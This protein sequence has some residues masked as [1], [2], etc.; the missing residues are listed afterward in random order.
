MIERSDA[1]GKLSGDT[2]FGKTS[3]QRRRTLLASGAAIGVVWLAAGVPSQADTL[4]TFNGVVQTCTGDQSDGVI[5]TGPVE[6]LEVNSLDQG[7]FP[8]SGVNGIDFQSGGAISI[9][10]DTGEHWI[11]TQNA[12]GI[13]ANTT[14]GPLSIDH[15][16]N[17]LAFGGTGVHAVSLGGID[18]AV[19]GN[20]WAGQAGIYARNSDAGSTLSV[21]HYGDIFSFAGAGIDV[22]SSSTPIAIYNAGR[23]WS[24]G[25]AIS[26]V[27]TSPFGI[28]IEQYGAIRS[29]DGRGIFA[30][31]AVGNV[32]VTGIGDVYAYGNGIEIL[33]S[34]AEATVNYSG[35]IFSET[36]RGIM[37]D[38][39]DGSVGVSGGGAILSHGDGIFA[40]ATGADGWSSV[41]WMGAI[42][43]DTGRGV[44]SYAARGPVS[45]TTDGAIDSQGD[46]IF[47]YNDGEQS[48]TVDHS[49]DI[50]AGGRGI[51]A[52]SPRGEVSVTVTDANISS[53]GTAI[54]AYNQSDDEGVS[55]DLTGNILGSTRGIHAESARGTVLVN[56][57]GEIV[58]TE[59]GIFAQNSGVTSVTVDQTGR[60]E[61]G[62]RGI[63]AQSAE[64][65]INIDTAGVID[66][67][68]EGI[69]AL[70]YGQGTI[71]INSASQIDSG[72][73]GI[74]AETTSGS[75]T[76]DSNGSIAAVGDGIFAKNDS[77]KAISVTSDGN[78]DAGGKGIYAYSSR[79]SVTVYS[80]GSIVSGDTGIH[81][82][83]DS[84]LA[85]VG[86][87][88]TNMGDIGADQ[89]GIYARSTRGPVTIA[90]S[91]D[92]DSG[93]HGIFAE[94]DSIDSSAGVSVTSV[95]VIDSGSLGIYAKSTRGAVG[96]SSNGAISSVNHGIFAQNDSN[97]SAQGVTILSAGDITAG[98]KGI[99]GY[100]PRGAVS[101]TNDGVV[102]ATGDGIFAQ[103]DASTTDAGISIVSMGDIGA[104]G[105]GIYGFSTRGAVHIE[106]EGAITATKSGIFAQ[107]DSNT[108]DTGIS[109][110]S[111][112]DIGAG[113]VGVYAYSTRGTISIETQGDIQSADSGIVAINDGDPNDIDG[114]K[115]S[116]THSGDVDSTTGAG[117]VGKSTV[118]EVEVA[119]I[120]GD[121]TAAKDGISVESYNNLSVMIGER[122]SVTGAS[123]YAGVF[124]FQGLENSLVNRGTISNAGGIGE[125]AILAA[126]NDIDV[127]NYG[128]IS[129][130][131]VLGP[132]SNS[133]NNL[134]GALFNMG[135]TV[136]LTSG[137]TLSNEGVLSPGGEGQVAVTNLTGSLTN[138]AGGTLLFDVDMGGSQADLVNVSDQASLD[139]GLALNFV[140]ADA[141]P[142]AYTIITTGGGVTNQSLALL[143]PLVVGNIAYTNGGNDVELSVDGFDFSPTGVFG[144][145]TAIGDYIGASF[146]AGSAGL[147]P[148]VLALLNLP[149]VDDVNDALNQLSPD[150]YLGDQQAAV[151]DALAFS[152]SMLSCRVAGGANAFGAEGE[153]GW[154]RVSYRHYENSGG[155]S[156]AGLSSRSTDF[157]GGAQIALGDGNW[158]LGGALGVRVSDRTGD[159]GSSSEGTSFEGG[160][161][162]K[163]APGPYLL[164]GALSV[165]RGSY[166]TSRSV[167]FPGFSDVLMGETDVS[168]VNGRLRA[169]YTMQ[170]GDFY[171][172]PQADFDTT[173]VHTGAFTETGG[174]ASVSTSATSNTMFT[175]TPSIEIGGQ[176]ALGDNYLLRPY[177]RGGVSLYANNDFA[178]S[179]VFVADTA[180]VTP[181]TI[182]TGSDEV[183]W[184][185]AAGIDML[186]AD[187]GTVQI[188]YGGSFGETTT[189][190]SAG[191]KLSVDF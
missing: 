5:A 117:I 42:T 30:D 64:G 73:R 76:I 112:G 40:Q 1:R 105:F 143:N 52:F 56:V 59:H 147:D 166:D 175:L 129:G 57:D 109:I 156:Q 79:G 50:D 151:T 177:L 55:V 81:A 157:A 95:G 67:A 27:S 94:N 136:N 173:Y 77:N 32:T 115:I 110:S 96:V 116:I 72:K 144:N 49:G 164:A 71:A 43:S 190:H 33:A 53:P 44:Y 36:G 138:L 92:I 91:G 148:I 19:D 80:G 21:M 159:N 84:L 99:Y 122:A 9:I 69:F 113:G 155:G 29:N 161:V 100:S 170:A 48:V 139:G 6:Q 34:S 106:N 120:D 188:F 131:V 165:S 150:I 2:T 146:Q 168:T 104:G 180:G 103:N 37:V 154:G 189:V 107:N 63:H 13:F 74:Y 28:N 134:G 70:N 160:A 97:S 128:T 184:N 87:L 171:F 183:L 185:V 114:S 142:N 102:D 137:N 191:A 65:A 38:A 66:A 20:I 12:D 15:T 141:T 145:G 127:E 24:S 132:W 101:I 3:L 31:A 133:F 8:A 140:S 39:P 68:A 11:V 119:L 4:C 61:T 22:D 46:G 82:Q 14:G 108:A 90:N 16:G 163:Y 41:Y 111:V 85:D 35:N 83:N 60:L 149:S 135:D 169:A 89:Y 88:V 174:V 167:M 124:L 98:G 181:F 18:I 152:D 126:E 182:N 130:N 121:V 176:M 51:Y 47:A 125:Y 123:G 86:V 58:S 7:I 153:C 93:F 17:F 10:S 118:S 186:N 45:V 62:G 54:H 25:D 178:L 179:G 78:I 187:V 162:L 26:A 23:I 158:R 172:R 75:V